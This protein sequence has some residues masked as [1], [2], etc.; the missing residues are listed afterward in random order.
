MSTRTR[1]CPRCGTRYPFR[2]AAGKTITHCRS[3]RVPLRPKRFHMNKRR[4]RWVHIYFLSRKGLTYHEYKLRL[5]AVG[6]DTC[7]DLNREQYARL[8]REGRKLPDS[9]KWKTGKRRIAA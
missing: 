3:C 7:K 5:Q 9:P 6:V 1:P 4:T 2:D 8:F